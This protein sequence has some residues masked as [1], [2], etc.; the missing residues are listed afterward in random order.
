MQYWS[1]ILPCQQG[2]SMQ[3]NQTVPNSNTIIHI[4]AFKMFRNPNT[5]EQQMKGNNKST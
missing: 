4:S 2:I 1:S 5:L 3:G